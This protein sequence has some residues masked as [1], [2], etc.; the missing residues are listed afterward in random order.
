[1]EKMAT[2]SSTLARII[3][4]T[5][6]PGR[7]QST[8]SQRVWH[9]WSNWV[10][11]QRGERGSF[12]HLRIKRVSPVWLGAAES[13]VTRWNHTHR[14]KRQLH[15]DLFGPTSEL[16][17]MILELWSKPG[18]RKAKPWKGWNREFQIEIKLQ[19]SSSSIPSLW[20]EIQTH[21]PGNDEQWA[22][23]SY[24]W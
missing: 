12:V 21:Y 10:H 15:S 20:T 5:E 8:G 6:E 16:C 23:E 7:L 22:R 17:H 9:N 11:T 24:F 3:P 1:M 13:Q 18:R 19:N 2:H 14:S 4:R